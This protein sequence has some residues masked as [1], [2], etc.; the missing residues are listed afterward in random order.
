MTTPQDWAQRSAWR[1]DGNAAVTGTRREYVDYF[2][3]IP[4]DAH[5]TCKRCG[6][7]VNN[8]ERYLKLHLKWHEDNEPVVT[9]TRALCRLVVDEVQRANVET[10]ST[11]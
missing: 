1:E 2:D 3:S 8:N 9:I 4:F 5:C 10:R 7:H 6:A 11:G